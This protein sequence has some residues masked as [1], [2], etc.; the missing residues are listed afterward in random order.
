MSTLDRDCLSSLW[1]Q[2]TGQS[3]PSGHYERLEALFA[4]PHRHYHDARHVVECLGEF[5]LARE[6]AHEPVAVELAIWFHDA[7]YDVRATDNEERSAEL[8]RHWLEQSDSSLSIIESVEKLVLA[9]KHHDTSLHID[10]PLIVD[11]DLSILGQSGTRFQEYEIAVRREYEWVDEATFALRRSEILEG[12]L[13]RNRIYTVDSFFR[14]YEQQAR[15]H[16]SASIARLRQE[17]QS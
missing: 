14:R 10:A 17:G 11:V 9:T 3:L 1:R 5:S 12:F 15:K 7:V 8:A 13:M 6:L 4:E 16:L 2:A